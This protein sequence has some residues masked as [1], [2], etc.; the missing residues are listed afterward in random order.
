MKK[1]LMFIFTE[2]SNFGASM[3][4]ALTK[5]Y[6]WETD[7]YFVESNLKDYTKVKDFILEYEPDI[8]SFSFKSFERN[9]AFKLAEFVRNITL[10][11]LN[12]TTIIVGGI[13]PTLMPDETIKS[14]FFDAVIVGDGM[15][16]WKDILKTHLLFNGEIINGKQHED[17]SVYTNFFYSNSQIERMKKTETVTVLT[18]IGCPYSCTFC[19]SGSKKFFA[20]PIENVAKYVIDLHNNYGVKNF[21]FLD[22][23]FSYKLERLK[24]F[25]ELIKDSNISFSSQVSCRVD[26]FNEDIAKEFVSMGVETVNFGVETTSFRL[27][28]FLNKNYSV[29]ECYE[30]IK[31]CHKYG[32]N[33]TVNLM[34][35]IPTQG[36]YDYNC[37]LEFV[38]KAKPDSVNC[39]FYTPYPGTKLY[40]HC[41]KYGYIIHDK[42]KFDWFEPNLDGINNIQIKLN[43]IDYN[44]ANKYVDKINKVMNKD[45]ILMRKMALIDSKPWIL[46]GTTRHYYFIKLIKK[47]YHENWRNCC[48]YINMDEEAG[49]YLNDKDKEFNVKD[50]KPELCITY[51]FLDGSD[52]KNVKKYVENNFGKKVPLLSISSFERSSSIEDI[53][54]IINL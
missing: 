24:K 45:K 17:K 11:L 3:L 44:L 4:C 54:K 30:A 9:Q 52:Y 27:L 38:E 32:L 49:F 40:E 46:I 15:G 22:D 1:L 48:G 36:E 37:A 21:H 41:F 20:F 19:H 35:G 16:V 53:I 18:A 47:L 51:S 42:N 34:F 26:T 28:N 39:F 25:H 7:I 14:G 43:N 31:L 8:I 12:D 33:S 23:L 50:V 6:G 29:N 10:N 5:E 2:N 13:H